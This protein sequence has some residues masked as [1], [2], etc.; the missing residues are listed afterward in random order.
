MGKTQKAALS[1]GLLQQQAHA[2]G[3]IV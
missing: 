1:L 3:R 2:T